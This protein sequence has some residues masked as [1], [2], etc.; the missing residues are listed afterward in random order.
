MSIDPQP[1]YWATRSRSAFKKWRGKDQ[2]EPGCNH[3]TRTVLG[4]RYP[5]PQACRMGDTYVQARCSCCGI[6]ALILYLKPVNH[7]LVPLIFFFPGLFRDASY[8]TYGCI[9]A[10]AEGTYSSVSR[11]TFL[12][13]LPHSL[14][15]LLEA[16]WC[17]NKPDPNSPLV[18]PTDNCFHLLWKRLFHTRAIRYQSLLAQGKLLSGPDLTAWKLLKFIEGESC[19]SQVFSACVPQLHSTHKWSYFGNILM[20]HNSIPIYAECQHTARAKYRICY[21]IHAEL[22]LK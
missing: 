1:A 20:Q 17:L 13:Y 15:C 4:Q 11:Y 6:P 16:R 5:C 3:L 19:S 7:L 9:P 8:L 14:S 18:T 10:K 12:L 2:R 22:F 21:I